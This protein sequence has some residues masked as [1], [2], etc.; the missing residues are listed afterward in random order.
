MTAKQITLDEL[1]KWLDKK[2]YQISQR[3]PFD[4]C[5]IPLDIEETLKIFVKEVLGET[6]K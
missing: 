1:V 3:S 2:D 6:T 4:E 5:L